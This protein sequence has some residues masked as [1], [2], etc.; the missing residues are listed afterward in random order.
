MRT[1]HDYDGDLLEDCDS[2]HEPVRTPNQVLHDAF[3]ALKPDPLIGFKGGITV[4]GLRVDVKRD[5]V[6]DDGEPA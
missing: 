2:L 3:L 6:E 4:D 1:D 5:G